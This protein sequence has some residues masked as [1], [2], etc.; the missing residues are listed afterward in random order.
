M[1][2]LRS[3]QGQEIKKVG[4]HRD[5][6]FSYQDSAS[7]EWFQ[8]TTSMERV[9]A[10]ATTHPLVSMLTLHPE[11]VFQDRELDKQGR[12]ITGDQSN[13]FLS[14]SLAVS[15]KVMHV[16]ISTRHSEASTS[17]FGLW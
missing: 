6:L 14:L 12:A 3:V 11:N 4:W 16:G 13:F 8:H 1:R 9:L 2:S 7:G 10:L 5:E 15:G 17:F